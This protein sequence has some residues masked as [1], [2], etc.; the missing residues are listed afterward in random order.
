MTKRLV[1][2]LAGVALAIVGGEAAL[3]APVDCVLRP[4][5]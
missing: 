2:I 3:A 1:A 4:W 5:C